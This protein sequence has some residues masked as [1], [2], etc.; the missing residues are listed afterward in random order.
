MLRLQLYSYI[1]QNQPKEAMRQSDVFFPKVLILAQNKM[2]PFTGG[3]V[4]LSNLFDQFPA[5]HLMF[6]HRDQD[7][8]YRTPYTEHRL[9][10]LY[11]S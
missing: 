2:Q 5:D 8:D 7:Y 1:V 6:L 9:I 4:V 11:T 3:G 10:P